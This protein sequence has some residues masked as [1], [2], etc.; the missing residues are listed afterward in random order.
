MCPF[1]VSVRPNE[2]YETPDTFL[3][4]SA[5]DKLTSNQTNLY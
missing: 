2:S 3:E 4:V 1:G 5:P